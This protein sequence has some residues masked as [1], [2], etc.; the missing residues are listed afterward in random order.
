MITRL[1]Q[2]VALV[3]LATLA[4]GRSV[5]GPDVPDAIKVPA[6]ED[7]VLQAQGSGAQVYACRQGTDGKLQW[8]LAG[9][10]A[11]LHDEN[12][13][14]IGHH[15]AGPTWKLSDGSEVRGKAT[16]QVDSPDAD[17]IPWLLVTATDHSGNGALT[18]VTSI[19]RIH[20][21]GG[22]A[23]SISACS[24]SRLDSEVRSSYTADYYFYA[25]AKTRS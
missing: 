18:R 23:P 20:T 24:P 1:L 21:K 6:G 22:R 13:S 8:I 2:V 17:S 25:P 16:A 12:G 3:G 4:Y 9:P 10:D 7:L 19:Q 11:Q 15:Y 5:S 14:V